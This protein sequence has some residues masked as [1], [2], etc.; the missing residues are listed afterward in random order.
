MNKKVLKVMLTLI[1]LFLL[2]LYI[3]KI[4]LPDQF[5]MVIENE[6]IVSFGKLI[7]SSWYLTELCAVLTSLITY[8]LYLCAVTKKWFL[9]WKEL[10]VVLITIAGIHALYEW[11]VTIAS[12]FSTIAMCLL[13]A[14]FKADLKTTATVFTFHYGAQLF[15]TKIRSLPML[16]TNVNSVTMM[17][18]A[19][20][21]FLW[22]LLFY[23]YYN[24]KGEH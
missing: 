16:L 14:L 3:I 21:A 17:L 1:A 7:D 8:W 18:M 13:P 12:G 24:Y 19:L 11:D 4:F 9:N 5:I 20:D 22:L 15:S 10:L 6:H 23:F 2:G